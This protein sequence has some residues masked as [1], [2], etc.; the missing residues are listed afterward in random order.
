MKLRE[1]LAGTGEVFRFTFVQILKS[2][3]NIMM[4][5]V[6]LLFS[7]GAFPVMTLIGGAGVRT[8][9]S[10][11]ECV[12]V[13]NRTD[14]DVS[15]LE[16]F[17]HESEAYATI[18]VEKSLPEGVRRAVRVTLTQDGEGIHAVLEQIG[19]EK[20][21]SSR[22][23]MLTDRVYTYLDKVRMRNAGL[24]ETQIGLLNSDVRSN[25]MDWEEYSA[26]ESSG[27]EYS[28]DR[29]DS[30]FGY[31]IV[32]MMICV[33]SVSYIIRS[34]VEE[35]ASKLVDLL[36]VSVKPT[37]LL[38]GKVLAV[39]VFLIFYLAIMIA[40]ATV[41]YKLTS[42]FL[43]V[44]VPTGAMALL[45]GMNYSGPVM[46][47]IIVTSALGYLSFGLLAGLCG[48][49]CSSMEES[50]GAMSTCL[51]LVM[52]GYMVS[53]MVGSFATGT[54][55]KVLCI[56]PIVSMF[57]APMQFA[58]GQIGFGI[59]A[60]SWVI[61]LCIVVLMVWLSAKVYSTLIIYKGKRMSFS[62]IIKL[63]GRKEAQS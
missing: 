25:W 46:A 49:G 22:V 4:M 41:S 26:P 62:Q 40:G 32:L 38:L 28:Q 47:V 57:M 54:F 39:L 21:G 37:A 5:V 34:V 59:V 58:S 12:V 20:V 11:I 55:L 17:F 52:T 23:Y 14:L 50:G 7:L 16:T 8:S 3:G 30:Q 19:S 6:A 63:A 61:Q 56:I 31:S 24:T 29:Y 2:K 36:L 15:A 45:T 53:I 13:D 27:R 51:L 48:A 43:D 35:K 10:E 44:P 33:Y 1:S 18:R 9:S 60:L 42:L